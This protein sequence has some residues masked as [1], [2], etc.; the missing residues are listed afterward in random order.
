MVEILSL[1]GEGPGG[2]C[3]EETSSG[4]FT[5]LHGYLTNYIRFVNDLNPQTVLEPLFKKKLNS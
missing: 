3:A 2:G 1:P 5:A 4:T